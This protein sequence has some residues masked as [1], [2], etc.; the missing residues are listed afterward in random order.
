MATGRGPEKIRV[1]ILGAG[2]AGLTLLAA[3]E[4]HPHIDVQLYEGSASITGESGANVGFDT[5]TLHALELL[6]KDFRDA[7]TKAGAVPGFTVLRT[8]SFSSLSEACEVRQV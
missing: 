3:L 8:V 2:I 1:A 7:I 5:N 4:K 6:G